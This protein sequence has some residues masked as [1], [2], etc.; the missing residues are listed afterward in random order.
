MPDE[1]RN[2]TWH[3]ASDKPGKCKGS[4]F[5]LGGNFAFFIDTSWFTKFIKL[6]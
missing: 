4:D 1:F 6:A 5:I 3:T 2:Q